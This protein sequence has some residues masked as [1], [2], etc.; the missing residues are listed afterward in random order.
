MIRGA[1]LGLF[2]CTINQIEQKVVFTWLQPRVGFVVVF[3]E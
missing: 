3:E 2:K 1:S